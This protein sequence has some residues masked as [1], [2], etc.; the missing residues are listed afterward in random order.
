M[1][2]KQGLRKHDDKL[3]EQVVINL[4]TGRRQKEC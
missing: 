4:P 1:Q 2:N 3:K